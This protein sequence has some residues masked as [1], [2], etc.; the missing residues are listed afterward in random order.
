MDMAAVRRSNLPMILAPTDPRLT[1][2]FSG[3]KGRCRFTCLPARYGK[4]M[5]LALDHDKTDAGD[6][7]K[8]DAAWLAEALGG[9]WAR[10][11]QPGYRIAVSRALQWRQLF[12][13]NWTAQVSPFW[14]GEKPTFRLGD[15]PKLTL[16]EALA[17]AS[18]S[19]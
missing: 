15:G 9:K 5:V 2:T 10:G 7:Y 6:I 14:D 1:A 8:D 13:A 17:L 12:L 3:T 16:K 4:G 19:T 11:H 18:Q